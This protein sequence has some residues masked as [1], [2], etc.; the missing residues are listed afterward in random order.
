MYG[1]DD[2]HHHPH[3]FV[4]LFLIFSANFSVFENQLIYGG[5]TTTPTVLLCFGASWRFVATYG[6]WGIAQA[7]TF[8]PV[9]KLGAR[10]IFETTK[11]KLRKSFIFFFS[12]S[13]KPYI[14]TY[15]KGDQIWVQGGGH[16]T[17]AN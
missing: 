9:L 4:L 17:L 11:P 16:I 15:G 14:I 13:T 1:R 10:L 2:L 7:R 3:H 8:G 6:P 5:G 12:L